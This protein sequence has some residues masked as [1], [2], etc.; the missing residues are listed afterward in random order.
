MSWER[1][2]T[3]VDV[4]RRTHK[5]GIHRPLTSSLD[6]LPCTA[7]VNSQNLPYSSFPLVPRSIIIKNRHLLLFKIIFAC[8]ISLSESTSSFPFLM[9]GLGLQPSFPSVSSGWQFSRILDSVSV[10]V[11]LRF[12][13]CHQ[14]FCLCSV[15][16]L[17]L[18][19][20]ISSWRFFHQFMLAEVQ[21]CLDLASL[22]HLAFLADTSNTLPFLL[23]SLPFP[24]SCAQIAPGPRPA[25]YPTS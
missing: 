6:R 8:I 18:L 23:S 2:F 5:P 3:L 7:F 15:P 12:S 14:P 4:T 19:S 13:L 22:S 1:V 16:V 9:P 24:K 17:K 25:F 20:G 11:I 21:S 10:L